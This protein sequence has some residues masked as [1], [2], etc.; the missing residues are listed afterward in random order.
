[1]PRDG[2]ESVFRYDF[3]ISETNEVVVGQP[4]KPIEDLLNEAAL[5]SRQHGIATARSLAIKRNISPV[6]DT[7]E[8]HVMHGELEKISPQDF[9]IFTDGITQFRE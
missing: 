3:Y 4:G 1:M 9:I 6:R 2:E 5:H 7:L 8:K